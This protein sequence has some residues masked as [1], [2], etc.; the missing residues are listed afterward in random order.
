MRA[1]CQ[2][3][4]GG[5]EVLD[6]TEMAVPEPQTGEVLVRIRAAG[7]NPVDRWIRAGFAPLLGD[8]P[9]VLGYDIS[10]VVEEAATGAT[11]FE[12]GDEVH[13]MTHAGGGY[14]EYI[15]TPARTLVRKPAALDHVEAAALPL[16][17][18]TAWQALVDGA[19][20]QSGQRVLIH[21]A[22]GGVGHLA[23]QIARALGAHVIGTAS[24]AKR[25]F[26]LSVGAHEV[27]DYRTVDFAATYRDLD[28][29]LNLV[30]ADSGTKYSERSLAAIR[31]GGVLVTAVER[32]DRALTAKAREAGV[33]YV[34]N[35]VESDYA[36]LEK[37]DEL[38]DRGKLRVRVS[39]VF[40]LERVRAAHEML[41]RGHI[42]GKIVLAI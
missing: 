15:R 21:G 6:L 36:Q 38:V 16:A 3:K 19:R 42:E 40:P 37:L 39:D 18:L 7:V 29:V 32:S 34:E 27:I 23:V 31:P 10:G 35:S 24:A 4:Y 41:E 28:V 30:N 12:P 20:L 5:P 13:G 14:A 8:L 2:Q 25:E 11:R 17:G 26:V 1:V 9:F 22:G 33:R